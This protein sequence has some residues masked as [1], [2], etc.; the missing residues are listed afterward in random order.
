[1]DQD[2][3]PVI[4]LAITLRVT[5]PAAL[6]AFAQKAYQRAWADDSWTPGCLAEAAYEAVIGSNMNPD[7]TELGLEQVDDPR[8]AYEQIDGLTIPIPGAPDHAA[9]P[10]C[11]CSPCRSTY[12]GRY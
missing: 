2:D 3:A 11:S 6:L 4:R 1:M 5:D 9:D 7:Y 10:H 8:P 12:E